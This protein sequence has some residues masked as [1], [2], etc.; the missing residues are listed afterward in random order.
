MSFLRVA[1]LDDPTA[2]APDA[3]IFTRSNQ[4]WVGLPAE[5]PAFAL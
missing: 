1:T 4:P 3:H 5:T 2:I